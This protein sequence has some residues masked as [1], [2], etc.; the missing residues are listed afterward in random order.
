MSEHSE[1]FYWPHN[2]GGYLTPEEAH[3]QHVKLNGP[4]PS[5]PLSWYKRAAKM[6]DVE[7]DLC[8]R[9]IWRMCADLGMCFTCIT[10][11]SDA[12]DDYELEPAL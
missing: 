3:R 7:C 8:G 5:Q 11:E 6:T 1:N 9:P 10:G 4:D 12:S 2:F